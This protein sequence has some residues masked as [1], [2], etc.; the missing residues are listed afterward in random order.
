MKAGTRRGRGAP[1]LDVA[2]HAGRLARKAGALALLAVMALPGKA[3]AG[4]AGLPSGLP[5]LPSLT[6]SVQHDVQSGLALHGYDP[7]AYRLEGQAVAGDRAYEIVYQG[8]V[9]RFVSAANRA[10]FRDA[11]EIYAPAFAGFDASAV[12]QG[13]AVDTDPQQFAIIGS[14]LFLFRTAENRK[15]FVADSTLLQKADGRWASVSQTLTR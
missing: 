8:V 6:E 3:D 2:H 5:E 15:R 9:W 1:S 4:T 12:A 14:R 10:A 13:R 7:V 11:P